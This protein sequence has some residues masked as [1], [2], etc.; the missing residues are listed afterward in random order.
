MEELPEQLLIIGTVI[1][2]VNKV[3]CPFL[4]DVVLWMLELMMRQG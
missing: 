4:R 2:D 1:N 3:L